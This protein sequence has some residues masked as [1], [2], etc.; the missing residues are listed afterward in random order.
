M[1]GHLQYYFYAYKTRRPRRRRVPRDLLSYLMPFAMS[2]QQTVR[3]VAA[4]AQWP[5]TS[6]CTIT[7]IRKQ[8]HFKHT[9]GLVSHRTPD[10]QPIHFRHR[11]SDFDTS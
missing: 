4:Y 7:G 11:A 9:F 8:S 10:G 5:A 1:L 6:Q 3:F 2:L